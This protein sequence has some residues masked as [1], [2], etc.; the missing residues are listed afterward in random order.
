MSLVFR[1]LGHQKLS[2]SA[3]DSLML[4]LFCHVEN[5]TG[6]KLFNEY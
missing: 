6:E 5:L 1:G 3:Y 2:H 4:A